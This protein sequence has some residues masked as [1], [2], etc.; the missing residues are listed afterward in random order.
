MH[1]SKFKECDVIYSDG[2]V[3]VYCKVPLAHI[4]YSR[5]LYDTLDLLYDNIKEIRFYTDEPPKE[6][7]FSYNL[8]TKEVYNHY[9][10]TV[11]LVTRT[12][13]NYIDT[14]NVKEMGVGY[15]G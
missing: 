3:D 10:Y 2:V 6:L 4:I 14:D 15:L 13:N 5:V 7:L 12:I 9:N 8:I 11:A 1:V